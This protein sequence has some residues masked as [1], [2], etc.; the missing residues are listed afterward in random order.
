MHSFL[1]TYLGG[2][3]F[4]LLDVAEWNLSSGGGLPIYLVYPPAYAP[5]FS[6]I[7]NNYFVKSLFSFIYK[8]FS[9]ITLFDKTRTC[10]KVLV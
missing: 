5:T 4:S 1:L 2:T 10:F 7:K 3:F 6:I 9:F 8:I